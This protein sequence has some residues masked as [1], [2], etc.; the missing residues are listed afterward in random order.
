V[1]AN[2][3]SMASISKIFITREVIRL[4]K[5]T[6]GLGPGVAKSLVP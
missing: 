6:E 1:F 5:T 3:A 2:A 4:K